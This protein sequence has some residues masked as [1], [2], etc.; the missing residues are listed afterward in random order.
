MDIKNINSYK[1]KEERKKE[2]HGANQ[3]ES[4]TKLQID[5]KR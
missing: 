5:K 4:N 3:K 2:K 1:R